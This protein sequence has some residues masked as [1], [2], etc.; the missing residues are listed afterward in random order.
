[1]G[2]EA[3]SRAPR[4]AN[5]KLV[6]LS[7][8]M[9]GGAR[10][11][12]GAR[13]AFALCG[14]SM[15]VYTLFIWFLPAWSLIFYWLEPHE[16]SGRVSIWPV[17]ESWSW[18]RK[19]Q[20]L[21]CARAEGRLRLP[22][23]LPRLLQR[24]EAHHVRLGDADGDEEVHDGARRGAQ[25]LQQ[26]PPS[27][28]V[29]RGVHV[30]V[31]GAQG[32]AQVDDEGA[33]QPVQED[34]GRDVGLRHGR[35][36]RGHE[37][38]QARVQRRTGLRIPRQPGHEVGDAHVPAEQH[39]RLRR[40]R[41]DDQRQ[42]GDGVAQQGQPP[43][44]G[45]PEQVERCRDAAPPLVHQPTR[46]PLRELKV[47]PHAERHVQPVPRDRERRQ[48]APPLVALPRRGIREAQVAPHRHRL[49]KPLRRGRQPRA[50]QGPAV[51]AHGDAQRAADHR[52][53]PRQLPPV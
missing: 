9:R 4:A 44:E 41:I 25:R 24:H 7:C 33:A 39:Q 8:R 36:E 17:C 42:P 34:F 22:L 18:R 29:Q 31:R 20:P 52:Q 5:A 2:A 1:M 30:A 40:P 38:R 32:G 46:L 37:E 10:H 45:Q 12:V 27:L 47:E 43:P 19:R 6:V 28:R 14:K 16:I 15:V 13:L 3:S 49:R 51:C 26:Q 50:R 53:Q 35:G 48:P 21:A 23:P 11:A